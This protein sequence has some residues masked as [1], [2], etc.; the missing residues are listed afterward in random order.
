MRVP[1]AKP[2]AAAKA[3]AAR[4]ATRPA[5]PAMAAAGAA[6]TSRAPAAARLQAA[7]AP[8]NAF[9]VDAGMFDELTET[10]LKPVAVPPKPGTQP[11]AKKPAKDATDDYVSDDDKKR[12][13]VNDAKQR[14]ELAP[15]PQRLGAYCI[16]WLLCVGMFFMAAPVLSV[17]SI[18]LFGTP[19][20]E[21]ESITASEI[22]FFVGL[23]IAASVG[24]VLNAGLLAWKSQTLGK[25]I[26]GLTIVDAET[27]R[28]A[29]FHQTVILRFIGWKLKCMI[30]FLGAMYARRD[31]WSLFA[32]EGITEHDNMAGTLVVTTR[33][34]KG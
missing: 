23:A 9:G 30:P 24:L 5:A 4:S 29:S 1:A 21:S 2:T 3:P 12:M 19:S 18:A 14:A 17:I 7:P 15:L 27:I 20:E 11:K 25:M 8:T 32:N 26:C 34:V 16:D 22:F 13:S 10:D 33:S 31:L 28:R 6:T